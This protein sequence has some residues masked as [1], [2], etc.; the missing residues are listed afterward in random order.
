MKALRGIKI[1]AALIL[2]L[3][4]IMMV[5]LQT[6]G[7]AENK[8]KYVSEVYVAYG[9]DESAAKNVL[10]SKGFTPIDGNLN[11]SGDTYVMMG[12]KTTD[13][14]RDSIT[15]IAVMNMDGEFNTTEYRE[16][17]RQRK[18]Q[19]AELLND[20]M[21]TIRE[22]RMNLKAGKAKATA[23]HDLLNKY[24]DDD[25][26]KKLGDLFNSET[27]QDKVGV[28]KSITDENKGKLPDLLTI[29]MQGN[30][31]Y[32]L[33]IENMLSL[34]ADTNENTWIDRFAEKDYDDMLDDLEDSRSDLNTPSKRAQYLDSVYGD[35]VLD[36]SSSIPA[37][38]SEFLDYEATGISVADATEA[39]IKAAFGDPDTADDEQKAT[40]LKDVI[41]WEDAGI[42]YEALKNYE[43]GRFAEGELLDFFMEEVDEDDI[44][45]YYSMAAAFTEGQRGGM[46]FV[47]LKDM[48]RY[49]FLDHDSWKADIEKK[50]KFPD[51]FKSSIYTG[52]NREMFKTDGSIAKTGAAAR[53]ENISSSETTSAWEESKSTIYTM[54]FFTGFSGFMYGMAKI[55]EKVNE[56]FLLDYLGDVLEPQG[57]ARDFGIKNSATEGLEQAIV[58]RRIGPIS[59]E[60][61]LFSYG[62]TF[63]K[64]ATIFLAVA[65]AAYTVYTFAQKDEV[66][67]KPIPKYF[68]DNYTSE[69]GESF[70]LN[71]QAVE[72]NRKDYNGNEKQSGDSADLNADEGKQWLAIY[73]SKNS[74]A[75]KPIEPNFNVTESTSA[76][77]GMSGVVHKLGEKGAENLSNT[78]Y[79][80]Y[81]KLYSGY[82]SVKDN[83]FGEDKAYMFFKLSDVSKTYDESAGNMTAS[84]IGV[85]TMALIGF[86][87]LILGGA[88]GAVI[89]VL[90]GKNKKK[91]ESE[92]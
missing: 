74:M 71:Y 35:M 26:G 39:D 24:T 28:N 68:V 45:R 14:I 52:I 32:I 18:T 13:N 19:V 61:E 8:G 27:L 30:S 50:A 51:D 7:A 53:E 84:T 87:G 78:N 3:T 43:G 72:C 47:S 25:S 54:L 36:L 37:L 81:S 33:T 49:A 66:K 21:A 16:V 77:S 83:I 90:V 82:K 88:L 91:N 59:G 12:Y 73:V 92:A 69:A 76:P 89:A 57:G 23:V 9:K 86:G 67:L 4:F 6:V 41:E 79:M 34:A 65:T 44:E 1:F 75:G 38:R 60:Y 56:D 64:F 63:F 29:L 31:A 70:Q 10:N 46:D 85:G 22:Y 40:I 2:T 17:L 15:D 80:N 42:L 58:N 62:V 20:F 55:G 48:I 5:P 11:K